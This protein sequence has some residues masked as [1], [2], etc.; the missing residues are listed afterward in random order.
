MKYKKCYQ[1]EAK[2]NGVYSINNLP[3][4]KDGVYG[5]NPDEYESIG[6][7]LIA[8]FMNTENVT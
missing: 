8:L 3:K 2:L 7:D 1:N 5:I 6:T 4:I